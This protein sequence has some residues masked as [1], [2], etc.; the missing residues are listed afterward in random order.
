MPTAYYPQR[1]FIS[2]PDQND[3]PSVFP[4]TVGQT[5]LQRK[6]PMWSTDVKTSVSGKERRRALWSY[7]IWRFSVSYD[8]LRDAPSRLDLQRIHA[9]FNSMQGQAGEFLFWDRGDN[10]VTDS[11]FALGDGTTTTFQVMRTVTIGGISYS[12]PVHAF[13]GDPVV[14]VDGTPTDVT[15]PERGKVQF[16]LAPADGS[17]LTWTGRFFWR[18][19]FEADEMDISQLMSGLWQGRGLDF[20]TVKV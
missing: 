2:A 12:E 8:V 3:D 9:F 10:T 4:Y 13:N 16:A 11:F 20:H 7:P 19:R 17:R 18:C 5:F 6:T 14:S 15:V 1:Y